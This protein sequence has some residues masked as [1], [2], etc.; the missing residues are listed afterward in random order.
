MTSSKDTLS[1]LK[2]QYED[3]NL[4]DSRLF[5]YNQQ[6]SPAE[7]QT[8]GVPLAIPCSDEQDECQRAALT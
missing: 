1:S 8:A 4:T 3:R 2:Q 6:L 7:L 5:C